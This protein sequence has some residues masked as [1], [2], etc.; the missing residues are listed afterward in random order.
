M[1]TIGSADIV[2][3][4]VRNRGGYQDDPWVFAVWMYNNAYTGAVA[5]KL[6]Y[7][8]GYDFLREGAYQGE[9]KLLLMDGV[10]TQ[11]GEAWLKKQEAKS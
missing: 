11:F 1:S 3:K 2:E 9:P 4:I 6:V 7:L 5:Y 10:I 8:K